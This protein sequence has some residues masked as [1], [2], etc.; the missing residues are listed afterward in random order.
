MGCFPAYIRGVR[1]EEEKGKVKG[2]GWRGEKVGRWRCLFLSYS[3]RGQDILPSPRKTTKVGGEK[4]LWVSLRPRRS[5]DDDRG[6][7]TIRP[8][9]FLY[10]LTRATSIYGGVGVGGQLEAEEEEE[11]AE[12]K[13]KTLW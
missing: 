3:G 5:D 2:K 13:K 8:G 12:E 9:H 4:K 1:Q 10:G 7:W 11:E 6:P